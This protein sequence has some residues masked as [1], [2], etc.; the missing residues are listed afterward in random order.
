[1]PGR[2]SK[3]TELL[4]LEGKSHRTKAELDQRKKA[5]EAMTTG[6]HM[7]IWPEVKADLAAKKEFN[8]IRS[9]LKKIGMDDALHESTIN[10]YAL[11]KA[12]CTEFEEKRE[13]F[14]K[15]KCELETEYHGQGIAFDPETGRRVYE[16]APSTYYKLLSTMQKS[17]IDCDKQIMAKRQMMLA[18]E[19]ENIM[20]IASVQ[21]SIPKKPEAPEKKGGMAGFMAKRGGGGG[22]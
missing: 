6:K 9:L 4:L 14:Y 1:M 17:I 12:E 18:I 8:R 11:L 15:S 13:Q 2:P 5:E 21:R 7:Q 20:T 19:K 10:R 3:P 16:L 22:A